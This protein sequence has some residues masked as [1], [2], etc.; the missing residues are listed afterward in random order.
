MYGLDGVDL[1]TAETDKTL[2]LWLRLSSNAHSTNFSLVSFQVDDFG[3]MNLLN[4]PHKGSLA[5]NIFMKRLMI[6]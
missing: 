5:G 3:E 4:C 1:V 2:L 6:S